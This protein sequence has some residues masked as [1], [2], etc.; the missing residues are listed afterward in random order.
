MLTP[1]TEYWVRD[2]DEE[3][4]YGIKP[5]ENRSTVDDMVERVMSPDESES[6]LN[7]GVDSGVS[8][9]NKNNKIE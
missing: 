7:L 9:K 6:A 1:G 2:D 3:K 8:T 5:V 4:W